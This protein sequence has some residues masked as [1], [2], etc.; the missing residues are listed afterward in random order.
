M[1]TLPRINERSAQPYVAIREA[2]VLPF[3]DRIPP[4]MEELFQTLESMGVQPSGPVFFKHDIVKMPE[5]VIEFGVP[6]AT[7]IAAQGR[8]VAGMLPGGRFAETTYFGHYDN[9]MDVNAVLIGWAR[10]TGLRWDSTEEPDGEH[11]AARLEI[12]HN[13]PEEEPDPE[14]WET[15]VSI[16]IAD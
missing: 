11:F 12:Y 1:L 6:V 9:L 13:S 16:K 15:T 4:I 7:P 14:K 10:H 5:L 2:V 8:L 3:D